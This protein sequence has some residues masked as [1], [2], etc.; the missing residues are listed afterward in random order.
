MNGDRKKSRVDKE[1]NDLRFKV[2]KK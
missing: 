1:N 2:Y